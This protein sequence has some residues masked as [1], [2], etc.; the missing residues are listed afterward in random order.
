ML[1]TMFTYLSGK[2]VCSVFDKIRVRI[3]PTR[4]NKQ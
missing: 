2:D 1:Q 4:T 3:E